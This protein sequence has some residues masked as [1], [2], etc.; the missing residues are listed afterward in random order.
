MLRSKA[1]SL[2]T[3]KSAPKLALPLM[4][5][6]LALVLGACVSGAAE[7]ALASNA[8]QAPAPTPTPVVEDVEPSA[9]DPTPTPIV[10]AGPLI[11][12]T[13]AEGA[14]LEAI[15]SCTEGVALEFSGIGELRLFF[16]STFS[17]LSR[18]WV[19]EANSADFSVTFGTWRVNEAGLFAALPDDRIADRIAN[20]G[21]DC[22]FPAVLLEADP[23]PPLFVAPLVVIVPTPV[24]EEPEA[25]D[26]LIASADLAAIRV[27]SGVYSCSQDFPE[28]ASFVAR[29][30]VGDTW[31]V[32]GRTDVTSYGLWSVDGFTGDVEPRD[33]RAKQVFGSCDAA[34]ITLS[35]EQASVRVWVATYDC[36]SSPPPLAAFIAPQESPHRWVVEGRTSLVDPE[37]G[38]GLGS[39]LFGLWLVETDTGSI[40]GLDS[41]ARNVR[42]LEC[43][44]PFR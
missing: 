14:V 23:A 29:M 43:F 42:S 16:D 7:P 44:Q 24:P 41:L 19:I 39:T 25:P 33:E 4:A 11:S 6:A 22:A 9:P 37:T 36:F 2:S 38:L 13:D 3:P 5:I 35:G 32:E 1:T 12:R 26:L 15:G 31:V 21:F 28:L 27:W 30:D 8:P 40:T 10:E 20:D 17:S 18:A 34:P